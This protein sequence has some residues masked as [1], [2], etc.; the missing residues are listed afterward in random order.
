MEK[1]IVLGTGNASVT[2]CFNT[3]FLL[4][5]SKGRY[6][7]VDA[8]GGNGILTCLEKAQVPVSEIHELFVTHKHTDH[9]LGVIWMV[10][11]AGQMMEKGSYEGKLHIYCHDELAGI[12]RQI[13][14]MTLVEKIMRLFDDRICIHQVEDGEDRQILDY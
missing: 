8:G 14:A 3:C 11:N 9:L 12:I 4:Q 2:K 6:F 5:D 7:M 10:R 1:L 13:C